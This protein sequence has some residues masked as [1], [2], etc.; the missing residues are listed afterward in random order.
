MDMVGTLTATKSTI[1]GAV[2]ANPVMRM[3]VRDVHCRATATVATSKT[4]QPMT[5]QAWSTAYTR[6]RARDVRSKVSDA[7]V[8]GEQ[9]D[10]PCQRQPERSATTPDESKDETDQD[11]RRHDEKENGPDAHIRPFMRLTMLMQ[12][13]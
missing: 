6:I 9:S 2:T 4:M 7:D 13:A 11:E 3:G 8:D 12:T 1:S 5:H 10:A